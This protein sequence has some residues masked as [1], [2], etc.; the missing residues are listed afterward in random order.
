[1]DLSFISDIE[2]SFTTSFKHTSRVKYNVDFSSSGIVEIINNLKILKERLSKG[3]YKDIQVGYDFSINDVQH[4]LNLID[5]AVSVYSKEFSLDNPPNKKLHLLLNQLRI[6]NN[7]NPKDI[8]VEVI[9]EIM[10][11]QST[12]AQKNTKAKKEIEIQKKSLERAL[13]NSKKLNK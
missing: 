7:T 13:K 1:M 6:N 8:S 11:P 4:I 10:A 9:K 12:N 3:E 5:K 2:L